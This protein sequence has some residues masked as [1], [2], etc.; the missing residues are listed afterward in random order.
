[1]NFTGYPVHIPFSLYPPPYFDF[2]MAVIELDHVLS[3]NDFSVAACDTVVGSYA[4]F[5]FLFLGWIIF[6]SISSTQSVYL[7]CSWRLFFMS[8]S[9]A[10][11]IDCS[12]SLIYICIFL[13]NIPLSSLFFFSLPAYLQIFNY[14]TGIGNII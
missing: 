12:L 11:N 13:L 3:D 4:I 2:K 5:T 6:K 1:M 7:P 14:A 10:S 8:T 9:A